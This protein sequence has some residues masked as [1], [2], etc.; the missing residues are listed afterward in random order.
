MNDYFIFLHL[1]FGQTHVVQ[2][3]LQVLLQLAEV[4]GGDEAFAGLGQAVP[5]QFGHLVVDEAEDAVGQRQDALWGVAVDELGEPL[6]H[7][8]GGLSGRSYWL[9]MGLFSSFFFLPRRN[10][11]RRLLF[12][13]SVIMWCSIFIHL[14]DH[15]TMETVITQEA[16]KT[17]NDVGKRS[18]NNRDVPA[19]PRRHND[20]FSEECDNYGESK[21]SVPS[22]RE[23]KKLSETR[24]TS[25]QQLICQAMTAWD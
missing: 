23:V 9:I 2:Q 13:I 11:R 15:V 3:L 21:H 4:D 16:I 19:L 14:D 5:G 6:L 20:Y 8:S 10:A 12:L 7:L 1:L 22:M 25:S 18:I 17:I 24:R